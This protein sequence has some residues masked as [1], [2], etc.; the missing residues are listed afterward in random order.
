MAKA[1]LQNKRKH[2]VKKGYI[3]GKGKKARRA[4][5]DKENDS[6]SVTGDRIEIDS[7]Q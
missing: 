3:K 5:R 4:A 6:G 7:A 2:A 1:Y